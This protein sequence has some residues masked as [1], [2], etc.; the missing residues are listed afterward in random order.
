L[1]HGL[2]DADSAAEKV[3]AEH[4]EQD[5]AR[6]SEYVPATQTVHVQSSPVQ[7]QPGVSWYEPAGHALHLVLAPFEYVPAEHVVQAVAVPPLET[8]PALQL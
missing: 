6:A 2:H 8:L 7:D 3:P 1:S 4:A 5:V